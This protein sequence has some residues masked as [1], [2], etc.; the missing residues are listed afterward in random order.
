[1][2]ALANAGIVLST[3]AVSSP[4][5]VLAGVAA[6]LVVGKLVGVAAFSWLAIR[7]G[8]GRLPE[9]ARWGHIVGVA[10]VAGIGFTVSLFVTGLAFDSPT[11]QDDAKIGTLLASIVAAATGATVLAVT[12]RRERRAVTR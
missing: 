8:L 10:C 3:D 5:A 4:S 2:F 9:G 1:V 12:A 7:V 6:G 11:L